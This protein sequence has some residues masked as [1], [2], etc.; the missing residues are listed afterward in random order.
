MFY[1][2]FFNKK[3]SKIPL[4]FKRFHGIFDIFTLDYMLPA[5]APLCLATSI[6]VIAR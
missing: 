2:R 6:L 4:I 3:M 1:N 5:Y